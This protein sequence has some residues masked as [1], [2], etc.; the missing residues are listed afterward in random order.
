M[1]NNHST[2]VE[3]PNRLLDKKDEL[4]HS[5][6]GRWILNQVFNTQYRKF[7]A[8]YALNWEF[9]K[10]GA[11][12]WVLEED[13]ESFFLDDTGGVRNRIRISQNLIKPMVK[14]FEGNAIRMDFN[15][16][17]EGVNNDAVNRMEKM[18]DKMHFFHQVEAADPDMSRVIRDNVPLGETFQ[19]TEELVRA[20]PQDIIKEQVNAL[21]KA[22]KRDVDAE[23]VKVRL[24]RYLALSGMGIYKGRHYNGK[25]VG[26]CVIPGSFIFDTGARKPDLSDGGF[27]G[28]WMF[29]DV[30]TL[31][32][33]YQKLTHDQRRDI[34]GT[35]VQESTGTYQK[36]YNSMFNIGVNRIP[37]YELYWKD[38]SE[39]EYGWIRDENDYIVF[40]RINSDHTNYTK[41]DLVNIEDLNEEQLSQSKGKV[42][43][44][45][46]VDH[47][48]YCTFIAKED[49]S[50]QENTEDIVLEYGILPYAERYNYAPDSV[51]W[52]YKVYTWAYEN[53]EVLSP[54]DDAIDPQRMINRMT[55]VQESHV[56]SSHGSGAI[57]AREAIDDEANVIS[58][59]NQSKPI[60]VEA[61]AMGGVQNSVG[62]YTSNLG[63]DSPAVAS[64]INQMK[65]AMQDMTGINEAMTGTM[66]GSDKLVGV[67]QEQINR[68][69]IL[70]EP[71]YFALTRIMTSAFE[72]MINLGKKIYADN[73]RRLA[74]M[75][76][77]QGREILTHIKQM[78]IE[79]FRLY[80][81]RVSGEE[82][83]I[84][85]GTELT[86]GLLQL[87]LLSPEVAAELMGKSDTDQVYAAM[88]S[89]MTQMTIAKKEQN[90]RDNAMM[91]EQQAIQ[92]ANEE[93]MMLADQ[94]EK[95]R[96]Q[97][98]IEK[99]RLV[100]YMKASERNE[101]S[102]QRD[103][104]KANSR[105]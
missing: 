69:T 105:Q 6:Y 67:M 1:I 50:T 51:K 95:D 15:A 60:V 18:L 38:F 70:Q 47:L 55:S 34:E 74:I 30:P 3:R 94:Q 35:A 73:P 39:D 2:F 32:E 81:E 10:G 66:G 90:D 40:E 53:G 99:D 16:R 86:I 52:P 24:A 8:K 100:D 22:M 57:I 36:M 87:G 102:L 79:D 65:I 92:S 61:A 59:M 37:V 54:I 78:S 25:Y 42:S 44:M 27:M 89:H 29:Y 5:K 46:Y 12:Q 68:G 104:L 48:R 11:G 49:I 85:L 21:L 31:F 26:E 71:F 13:L 20:N 103:V 82:N 72:Q 56:N 64:I 19:D 41:A 76:G 9:F 33:R 23:E 45:I 7:Q 63:K 58:D 101:N 98:N 43:E 80:V 17:A 62:A 77:D 88:R 14:Q 91:E 83:I 96:A 84:Q 97:D 28:E 75:V 4:Y 93:A